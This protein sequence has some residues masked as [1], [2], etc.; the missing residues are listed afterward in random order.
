MSSADKVEEAALPVVSEPARAP[1]VGDVK[2]SDEI[3]RVE[4]A[5][6][7]DAPLK[8]PAFQPPEIIRNMTPEERALKEKKLLRK[9]DLRLLPMI[10]IMY[11]LNYIDR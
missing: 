11:I 3:H 8:D 9:I 1:A 6:D 2:A 7:R 10:V 5:V 4:S